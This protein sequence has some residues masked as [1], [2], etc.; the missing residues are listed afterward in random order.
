M[1]FLNLLKIGQIP[2]S[3]SYHR[4]QN[5]QVLVKRRSKVI[6]GVFETVDGSEV[7]AL[8]LGLETA[9]EQHRVLFDDLR[10]HRVVFNDLIR[11]KEHTRDRITIN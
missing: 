2:T 9:F 3:F 6:T 4:Q 8:V 11:V 5:W 10:Y 7:E 1:K